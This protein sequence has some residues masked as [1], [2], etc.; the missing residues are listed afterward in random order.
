MF[1]AVNTW[2]FGSY[3]TVVLEE[4]EVT[5]RLLLVIMCGALLLALGALELRATFGAYVQL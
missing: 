2:H 4:V 5:P 3:I 1:R